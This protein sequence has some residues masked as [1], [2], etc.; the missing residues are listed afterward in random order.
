MTITLE[1][2]R[3]TSRFVP[4]HGP[5]GGPKGPCLVYS[6]DLVIDL[7]I[8]HEDGPFM[9]TILD[10]SRISRDLLYLETLLYL[11]GVENGYF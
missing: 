9:L 10:V 7:A 3:A 6:G 2:F 4:D 8:D 1:E 11:H 5:E